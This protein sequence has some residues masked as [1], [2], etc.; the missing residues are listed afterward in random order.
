MS[1]P[2]ARALKVQFVRTRLHVHDYDTTARDPVCGK[3]VTHSDGRLTSE[4][5]D[6]MYSFCSQLCMDRFI[7]QPDIFT[8]QAGRGQV[9]ERDRALRPDEPERALDPSAAAV[10]PTAPPAADPGG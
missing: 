8:A 10:I 3:S 7:E 4:Y 1:V 9:A 6:V 5:A 2:L